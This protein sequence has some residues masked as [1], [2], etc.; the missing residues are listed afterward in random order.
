MA[1]LITLILGFLITACSSP[2]MNIAIEDLSIKHG[3]I[4]PT[5]TA[6]SNDN[7]YFIAK[8][9]NLDY[10]QLSQINNISPSEKLPIGQ[11][12]KLSANAVVAENQTKPE[13]SVPGMTKDDLSVNFSRLDSINIETIAEKPQP[14]QQQNIKPVNT[15]IATA[16]IL[17]KN[18]KNKIR[19]VYNILWQWPI[20]GRV[21]T[22]FASQKQDYRG[23]DIL[24][25]TGTPIYAAAD[26]IVSYAGDDA[27]EKYGRLVIINHQ[28]EVLSAYAHLNKIEVSEGEEV[29]RGQL[30]ATVGKTGTDTPKLHF[31]VRKDGF[32]L[33]PENVLPK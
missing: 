11:V 6:K 13:V 8:K 20:D 17:P 24:A 10:E 5:Y 1:K 31:E 14:A 32:L 4:Q 21:N 33:D 9:F 16:T 23:I 12:V 18:I 30:L 2:S 28:D 22:G 26:G 19:K 25:K 27:Y 29:H 3:E 7:L 15:K